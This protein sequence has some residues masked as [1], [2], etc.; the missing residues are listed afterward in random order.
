MEA[1]RIHGK[2]W[3][4]I[5]RHVATRDTNNIRAHAQKF[6][7]KLTKLVQQEELPDD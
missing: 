2:E 1:V 7:N 5:Q 4:L 3:E 6:L